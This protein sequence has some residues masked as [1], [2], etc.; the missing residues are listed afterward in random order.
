M[1]TLRV[2]PWFGETV[3]VYYRVGRDAVCIEHRD[4]GRRVVPLSWTDFAPSPDPPLV[5]GKPVRLCVEGAL[6]LSEW[7]RCRGEGGPAESRRRRGRSTA[8]GPAPGD[9]LTTKRSSGDTA[10]VQSTREGDE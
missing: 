4:A 7:A 8:G 5:A 3:G 6:A 1:I 2:H 9:I 10:P